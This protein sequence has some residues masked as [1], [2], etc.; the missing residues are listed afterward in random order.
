MKENYRDR[1]GDTEREVQ[2]RKSNKKYRGEEPKIERFRYR[3]KGEKGTQKE[4]WTVYD[5][6][7]VHSTDNRLGKK[8]R[9]RDM[10]R[11]MER[12]SASERS[13]VRVKEIES[14]REYACIVH[15]Y[16]VVQ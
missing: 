6:C 8:Q 5:Y 13:I 3:E 16:I 7:L 14:K 10:E 9:K 15:D 12:K 2:K 4:F 1:E 11:E